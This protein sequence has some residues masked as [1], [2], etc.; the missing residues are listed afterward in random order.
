MKKY[1]AISI[2]VFWVL[3]I[4]YSVTQYTPHT[5]A[6]LFFDYKFIDYNLLERLKGSH[7]AT[8]L[9]FEDLEPTI[10]A[11]DVPDEELPHD[12]CEMPLNSWIG[13]IYHYN[14]TKETYYNLP[15]SGVVG[16]MRRLGYLEDDYPYWVRED[17]VKMFGNYVMVAAPLDIYPRGSIVETSLGTG[18]VCDTGEMV[19]HWLDIAVDW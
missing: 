11:I 19:G 18:I 17:G 7:E 4:V 5:D 2:L 3:L 1:L 13:V 9:Y 12:I 8:E 15:M 14:G 6:I 10:E 16:I